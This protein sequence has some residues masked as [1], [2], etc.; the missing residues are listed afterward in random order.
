MERWRIDAPGFSVGNLSWLLDNGWK[1]VLNRLNRNNDKTVP[2]KVVVDERGD[3]VGPGVAINQ[4]SSV[5]VK[6][7]SAG[8]VTLLQAD[9]PGQS[10]YGVVVTSAAVPATR[11]TFSAPRVA[12]LPCRS[13]GP[14]EA[15][16]RKPP[17]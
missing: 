11:P 4:W 8:A 6:S 16:Y 3:G 5:C 14:G 9:N 12:A 7:V 10:I 2:D 17:M 15:N 1:T 13:P